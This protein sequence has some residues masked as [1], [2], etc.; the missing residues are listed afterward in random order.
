[1]E[2]D[3]TGWQDEVKSIEERG[4]LR[5]KANAEHKQLLACDQQENQCSFNRVHLGVVD[6]LCPGSM[7]CFDISPV[8][9]L[10]QAPCG[11]RSFPGIN[12]W[13]RLGYRSLGASSEAA[14]LSILGPGNN[15]RPAFDTPQSTPGSY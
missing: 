9:G 8:R 13:A 12:D 4:A 14:E 7:F 2:E 5:H 10:A 6:S 11:R 15:P 3:A 1:M